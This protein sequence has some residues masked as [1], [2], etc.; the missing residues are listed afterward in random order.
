M[1]RLQKMRTT[2]AR[3]A[4]S[5]DL[6]CKLECQNHRKGGYLRQLLV[7]TGRQLVVQLPLDVAIASAKRNKLFRERVQF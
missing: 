7:Q 3:I 2:G 1:G 5:D 4:K 6:W